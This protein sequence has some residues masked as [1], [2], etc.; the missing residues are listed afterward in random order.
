VLETSGIAPS[1]WLYEV[2]NALLVAERRRRLDRPIR[3]ALADLAALDITI[4]EPRGFPLTEY[5][6]AVEHELSVY[7]AAYIHIAI[8][9]A[10]PLATLDVN[11]ARAATRHNVLFA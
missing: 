3:H 11:L 5:D 6:L 8:E 1:I 2:A 4:V 7:D 9:H 10:T